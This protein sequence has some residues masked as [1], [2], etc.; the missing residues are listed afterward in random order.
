M[1][2]KMQKMGIDTKKIAFRKKT[3]NEKPTTRTFQVDCGAIKGDHI[4]LNDLK[5]AK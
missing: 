5:G 1:I 3:N 2:D 4:K